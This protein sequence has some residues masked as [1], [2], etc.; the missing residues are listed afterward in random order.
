MGSGS[1]RNARAGSA[2]RQAAA[3]RGQV[4]G[5][6]GAHPHVRAQASKNGIGVALHPLKRVG[7]CG[8][9]G[10]EASRVGQQAGAGTAPVRERSAQHGA[11][12]SNSRSLAHPRPAATERPRSRRRAPGAGAAATE[13]AGPARGGSGAQG[14]AARPGPI[15]GGAPTP[16]R[17]GHRSARS[18][19]HLLRVLLLVK[20]AAEH[21]L[22]HPL[23]PQ[24][25]H[26]ALRSGGGR[27]FSRDPRGCPSPG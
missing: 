14:D 15:Q 10:W 25:R 17:R 21:Q 3:R 4:S 19:A 16:G 2:G 20:V 8:C 26:N 9:G 18:V 6:A 13:R 7:V 1:G 22:H 24:P 5:A 27:G 12:A 23:L 11:K